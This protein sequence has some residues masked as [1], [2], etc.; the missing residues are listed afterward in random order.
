[1][2][3]VLQFALDCERLGADGITV[4]P[5]PDERHIRYADVYELKKNIVTELNIEGNPREQK[6]IDLVLSV[7]P[8]QVTL[9]TDANDAL[10]SDAGWNCKEHED[11]L[12]QLVQL[13]H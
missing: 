3:N 11:Y 4:H 1:M 12:R 2:P 10:T 5:R 7:L 9:V 6:F 8:A 13:F